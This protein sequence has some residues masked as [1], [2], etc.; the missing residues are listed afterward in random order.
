MY[1]YLWNIYLDIYIYTYLYASHHHDH[2]HHQSKTTNI[3]VYFLFLIWWKKKSPK[4]FF[5]SLRLS[6]TGCAVINP[7]FYSCRTDF[8]THLFVCV[9]VWLCI[10]TF[11]LWKGMFVC[12]YYV[13]TSPHNNIFS[14]VLEYTSMVI[15]YTFSLSFIFFYRQNRY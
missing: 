1:V 5:Y 10:C 13:Q 15:L 4:Q 11:V 6:F 7:F 9:C 2:H 3:C 8:H 14:I 12:D